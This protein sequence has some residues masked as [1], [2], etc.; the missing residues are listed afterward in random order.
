MDTA[1]Y[2]EGI[3]YHWP[4]FRQRRRWLEGTFRR[5]LEHCEAALHSKDMSLRVRLDMFA[6]ISQFIMPL[7]LVMELLIRGF[8]V[9]T[10]TAPPHMIYSSII[11]GCI[12]GAAFFMA[13]RYSLRR[14]DNMNRLQAIKE[15]AETSVYLLVLWFP[16]VIFICLKILFRPKDM[17]WGK[18]THGLVKEEEDYFAAKAKRFTKQVI[19]R[20]REEIKG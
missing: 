20:V 9:I 17:N 12:I 3:I 10:H 18:T 2:E 5:Y 15:A 8:K 19:E 14:Y 7:W 16:L 4:L 1:V 6:Y 11:V 13:A